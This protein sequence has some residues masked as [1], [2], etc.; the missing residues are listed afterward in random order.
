[1][2]RLAAVTLLAS[3]LAVSG[4]SAPAPA[5]ASAFGCEY[6]EGFGF[7]FKGFKLKAPK[8]FLCHSIS[9][10]RRRIRSERAYYG[11]V[12]NLY[13]LLT[14][15][16]CNWRIDFVYRRAANGRVYRRDRGRTHRRCGYL[17]SRTVERNKRLRYFGTACAQ[18]Y[19][20][21]KHRARQCHNI[22][23]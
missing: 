3:A 11:P 22:T 2:R 15:R 21:G 5:D 6:I 16:V 14:G 17:I 4:L 10:D 18:L 7:E 23:G 1:M 12:P 9:G 8:G 19:V 20:N 13:G